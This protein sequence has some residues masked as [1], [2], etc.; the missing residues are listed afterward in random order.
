[1]SV[2]NIVDNVSVMTDTNGASFFTSK[3]FNSTIK[4]MITHFDQVFI[5]CGKGDENL[6]LMALAEFMPG[7]VLIAGLRK[8]RKVDIENIKTN[9]P[10]DLL[11]YD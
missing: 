2:I 11:F 9:Q 8:T 5:C 1:M 7:L 6:G 10:V 3:N 4:N